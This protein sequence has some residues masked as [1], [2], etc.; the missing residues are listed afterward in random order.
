MSAKKQVKSRSITFTVYQQTQLQNNL[1]I[2]N[3][4]MYMHT[5]TELTIL[6]NDDDDDDDDNNNNH[7]SLTNNTLDQYQMKGR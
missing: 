2:I 6:Y 7:F 4:Y 3:N 5:F 1:I